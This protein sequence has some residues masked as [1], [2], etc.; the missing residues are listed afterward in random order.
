MPVVRCNEPRRYGQQPGQC[1]GFVG[2]YPDHE[3]YAFV[4]IVAHSRDAAQGNFVWVCSKC[5]RLHEYRRVTGSR[6]AA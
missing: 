3:L 1:K 5:G 4:R 6:G 2:L